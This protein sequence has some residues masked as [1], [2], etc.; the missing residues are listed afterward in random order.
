MEHVKD[1]GIALVFERCEVTYA[2]SNNDDLVNYHKWM[3]IGN[4]MKI[5]P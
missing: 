1:N 4:E 3:K 2:V 5:K